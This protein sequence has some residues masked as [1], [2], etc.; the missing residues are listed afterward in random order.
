MIHSGGNRSLVERSPIPSVRNQ[1]KAI[2]VEDKTVF[3][4]VAETLQ[5]GNIF[6]L[7]KLSKV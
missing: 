2:K 7:K 5:R 1:T 6:G 4:H 3:M